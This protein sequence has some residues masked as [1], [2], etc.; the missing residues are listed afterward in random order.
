MKIV[1]IRFILDPISVSCSSYDRDASRGSNEDAG[2]PSGFFLSQF[3]DTFVIQLCSTIS[4]ELVEYELVFFWTE[5][6]HRPAYTRWWCA[7]EDLD[8]LGASSM[9]KCL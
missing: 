7:K 6:I 8:L 1:E 9:M 3:P 4:E 5:R 2:R